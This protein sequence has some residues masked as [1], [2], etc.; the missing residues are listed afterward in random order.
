M[1]QEA[2]R[3]FYDGLTIEEAARRIDLGPYA[4]WTEPQRILFNIARAYRELR[5]E[6]FDA[7]IDAGAM[8]RAMFTLRRERHA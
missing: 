1:Q 5:G 4:G 8:L 7:P 2:T 3:C 6:P